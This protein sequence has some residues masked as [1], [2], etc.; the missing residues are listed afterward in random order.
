VLNPLKLIITNYPSD[1]VEEM[2]VINNPEDES[3]GTRKVPFCNE[4]YIEQ[5]D[6]ME[7]PP[8][9]YFR[10]APGKEVRLKCAY[11]IKC[12]SVKKNADGSIADVYCT[13][14][15]E[16]RSGSEASNRKVKGTLHWVSARH[17]IDAE[18]RLYDRLFNDE[19][20]SGHK[21]VDY[22]EFLNPDSLKVL[23][24]CKMEPSLATAKPLDKFQFQ[25]LG[26]FCVDYDS[27]EGKLVF[28]RTVSLKDTW[29]K[30]NK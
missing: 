23:N 17:A 13:Y 11:I 9:T 12:E 25:R 27:K 24:G 4:M 6:F 8:N 3:M 14:D 19:D 15:P 16:T 28:N 21:D 7:D 10:L 1:K 18:V 2:E 29:S 30:I 26:Y 22:R 5:D 20:P